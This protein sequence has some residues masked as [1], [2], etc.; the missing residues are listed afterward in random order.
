MHRFE[1]RLSWVGADKGPTT[2][3]KGY[4][5]DYVIEI[6]GKAPLRGSAAT[7][8]LG[9]DALHNPEDLLVASLSACHFLSYVAVCARSGV[10]VVDYTDDAEGT[11]A[12]VD[13]AMRFTE[14]ILRPETTVAAGTDEAKALALHAKASQV[15]FI[16]N[17]VSFPVRHEPRILVARA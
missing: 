2:T 12:V 15:C 5:R 6:D 1:T 14:V 13:G 8:F 9:D 10:V 17:S 4:S 3:Y 11:M 16:R 7:A